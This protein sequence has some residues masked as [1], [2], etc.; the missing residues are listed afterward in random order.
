MGSFSFIPLKGLSYKLVTAEGNAAAE[1]KDIQEG[2][3]V[4]SL[5]NE[6]EN[7]WYFTVQGNDKSR[8]ED[9]Y[10]FGF[11]RQMIKAVKKNNL[12][13][14]R[15]EFVFNKKDL[16]DGISVITLFDA[17]SRPLCERLVFKMPADTLN[18]SIASE[19]I[20][21]QRSRVSMDIKVNEGL[22]ISGNAHLSASVFMTD[23]LQDAG[24]AHILSYLMLSSELKGFIE[25]PDYYFTPGIQP[26]AD[27]E[28]LL[29]T[30][31]W[32]RYRWDAILSR[33]K[34]AFSFFPDYEGHLLELQLTNKFSGLKPD[35]ISATLSIPQ[36]RY[37]FAAS[38][39]S[40]NGKVYFNLKDFYGLNET[41]IRI[42]PGT[43][44]SFFIEPVNPFSASFLPQHSRFDIQE[45]DT[46]CLSIHITGAQVQNAFHAKEMNVY[47]ASFISDTLPFFGKADKTYLLDNY[48]RFKTIEE[49]LREYVTEVRV[50][51]ED[52]GFYM[53]V[54]DQNGYFFK[55][56][57]LVLYDGIP[58]Y[59][60]DNFMQTDPLGMEKLEVLAGK[61]FYGGQINEGIV[62]FS[63]YDGNN[64]GY[65]LN[66]D[67]FVFDYEGLQFQREFFSPVY[68]T[69]DA[70][71]SRMPDQRLT[72]YWNAGITTD[73]N[74]EAALDFYTSDVPGKYIAVFEG[75]SGN[76]AAGTGIFPFEV[77]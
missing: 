32:R 29:L 33:Q 66:K 34:P 43:A 28:N 15:A 36:K 52:K 1:I 19:N 35:N 11:T 23:A 41:V 10:L 76:G 65:E 22:N 37:Q 64:A 6:D 72:L 44:D 21:R 63:S 58:V 8:Y 74:G 57:P 47:N 5:N 48:T 2:G 60:L 71:K 50:R 38:P 42:H 27:L 3:Y 54:Q 73:K 24:H 13:N 30:H 20:Y 31:G 39:P 70:V 77:K 7:H 16:G 62:S 68:E 49:I 45:K 14:G 59:D 51:K 17:Y 55:N 4:L 53:R 18:I 9:V 40:V 12:I 69:Q 46:A 61:N 26:K 25:E 67:A 56:D 75:L